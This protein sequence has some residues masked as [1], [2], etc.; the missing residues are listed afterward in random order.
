M[1][2]INDI[3]KLY[4]LLL[5]SLRANSPVLSGNMSNSIQT[6]QEQNIK[7]KEK[8]K[9]EPKDYSLLQKRKNNI[10]PP[11]IIK[12]K[13]NQKEKFEI[14]FKYISE[15]N[16]I[17]FG[18]QN[19]ECNFQFKIKCHIDKFDLGKNIFYMGCSLCKKSI[20][21]K[22]KICCMGC[23]AI[24]LYSFHLIVKDPTGKCKLFFNDKQGSK[25]MGIPAEK[26]RN[27]LYDK[28]PI[29]DM[30]FTT[31]KNDFFAD[32]GSTSKSARNSGR[33]ASMYS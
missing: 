4:N 31:Y 16:R 33:C 26:F 28:T 1:P 22:D 24:P 2:E 19:M 9:D 32:P 13:K 3:E 23:S 18:F 7:D 25:L 10:K 15:I 21:T 6:Q 29:G 12:V 14:Q 27:Y 20:K 8:E 30:I 17:L 11:K 5:V